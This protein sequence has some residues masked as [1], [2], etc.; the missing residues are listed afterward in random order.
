MFPTDKLCLG[1]AQ[2][3]MNYGVNNALHR[4]P[5]EEECFLTLEAALEAGISFFDTASVYGNAE[6]ILGRFRLAEKGAITTKL[7]ADCEDT[8]EAVLTELEKSLNRLQTNSI[9]CYMLHRSSDMHRKGIM[10]GMAAA[11]SRGLAQKIGVSVY[12]PFEAIEAIVNPQIDIV[13]IPCNVLDNRW[14]KAG[15]FEKAKAQGKEIQARSVFL[16]GLLLMDPKDAEA[17]VAGSGVYV[18]EFQKISKTHG[19]TP[20][21]A[22]FLFILGNEN[23]SQVVFGVDNAEQLDEIVEIF[24]KTDSFDACKDELK[25]LQQKINLPRKVLSPYLWDGVKILAIVQARLSSSRLPKKVLQDV[26][27]KPMIIHE[28]ER[29]RN[30]EQI[31]HIVLAT[32]EDSSDDELAE[33]VASVADIYRGNL[34]DVL[35]R[36]YKCAKFYNAEHVVRIT[37]DCPVIDW[38]IVDEVISRHLSEK[39]DYTS[40][41]ERFPDGLDTEVMIFSALEKSWKEAKLPSEREHVTQYVKKHTEIFKIGE[42]DNKEDFSNM[43]WTVDEPRDLEFIRQI[44]K[45]LYLKNSDFTTQDVLE[46]LEENPKLKEI[47]CGIERNEGLKKSLQADEKLKNIQYGGSH[48]QSYKKSKELLNRALKVTP[49][50]AQTY[51]KSYRYFCLGCA[52]SFMERGD[53]CYIYDVDGNKFIDY[54]CALGPITVGYNRK[55]VNEAVIEQVN[56]F[57][58]AS[59]QSSL[60][61][62]LAEKLCQIVPC[63]EMVRFVKNGSDATTSA[64]RLARAYTGKE[65]VLMSGYHGMHDWSIGASENHKGVPEAV[66]SLTENFKYNDLQDLEEKL[67]NCDIAAVILEPIQSD[68]PKD[69]YLQ[70]VKELSH[71]YGAVLIFD[72]VVSGF[73]YALGGASELYGVKPDLASFGKGMAN[74]Y[75]ISAVAGRKELL[76]QIERGVFVSTTFGGDAVSMAAALAT[77]KI[78]EQPGFYEHIKSIGNIQRSGIVKLIEK[79]KLQNVLSVTGLP[80]HAGISFEGCGSLSYLDIQSVYSQ[81]MINSGI[82][83]FAIYNLNAA[84]TEKEAMAYLDA[85]EKAFAQIKKA[86]DADSLDGILVGGKVDPVFKRNIK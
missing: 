45:A 63:A 66:R 71:K 16:Q 3:G 73:R 34:N 40:L 26:C 79:Y 37:G 29:L 62:E 52:P 49:L 53:G 39:N 18:E 84:H 35:D 12:E 81:E 13:Q 36:Y 20:K 41:T 4:Q 44:F 80:V 78:L 10:A 77:I 2:M 69:G 9:Y 85:S 23:I 76:E 57:A 54:M 58:S 72:E 65:K 24:G 33:T 48:M 1:T 25:L 28:L 22:A 83:V 61:V 43:R 86:V 60:E 31:N 82:L 32:S 21:E 68:G 6:E 27:G 38:R 74:G 64:I 42:Y 30:S 14:E 46:L 50:A 17:K 11:K 8:A 55:E 15:V 59:L 51:S 75:A 67:K 7:R 70:G 19:F 5:T 47:N 56:K